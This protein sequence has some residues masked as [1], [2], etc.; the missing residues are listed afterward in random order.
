[1][2]NI[3]FI[4][5]L[6]LTGSLT[7]AQKNQRIAYIDMEYIL[8]NVPEYLEAQNTLDT[9]VA[10]WKNNLDK[11]ARYIEVLKTDLSD[12]KAILTKDLI[13][14]KEE[15]IT[16]KQQELRRLESLYFG[17]K[18]DMFL[19][20]K[21]LVQPVQDQVYNAIQGIAARKKYDFVFDK[22]SDLVMLY[23]NKK[24]DISELVLSSIGRAKKVKERNAKKNAP[25]ELTEK[26]QQVLEAKTAVKDKKLAD[27]EA[28]KKAIQAKREARLKEREAKRLLLKKKKEELLKK[29][30]QAKKQDNN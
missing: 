5:V 1:M 3:F 30:E 22:S 2:K 21:Q 7:I 20:R 8:E 6:L 24:H 10:K 4:I 14:E 13:E 16:L 18:G 17:P 23:S 25:R 11:Q 26:Q 19:L 27:K 28:Q 9:K 29:K 12:E 15:E